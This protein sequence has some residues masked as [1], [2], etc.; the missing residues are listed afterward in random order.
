MK[1]TLGTDRCE[2]RPYYAGSVTDQ[3]VKWLNDPEVVQFSEQRHRT[4]TLISVIDYVNDMASSKDAILWGIY[5]PKLIG[6][7]SA[8]IDSPNRIANLGIMIG[9][10]KF[11]RKG[12]GREAWQRVCEYLF[13][14]RDIRK[15][16]AGC[17]YENR[18]MRTLALKTGMELEAVIHDHFIVSGAPQ[19]L[20]LY[21]KIRLRS[22]RVSSD[23]RHT[24]LLG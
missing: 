10:K 8:H 4:H 11:W 3:H 21:G 6:T 18:A 14:E 20:L 16:E 7:I 9:D 1:P 12:Y 22:E 5:A 24:G 15:I 13:T 19:H 17:H 23:E 2:L